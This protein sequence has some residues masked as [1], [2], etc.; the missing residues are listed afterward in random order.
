[1]GATLLFFKAFLGATLFFFKAFL[2]ATRFLSLRL[3][4]VPPSLSVLWL[5]DQHCRYPIHVLLLAESHRTAQKI[6]AQPHRII[7]RTCPAP[8]RSPPAAFLE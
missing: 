2:C 5:P 1:L 3:P 7:S 6:H 8:V 4:R